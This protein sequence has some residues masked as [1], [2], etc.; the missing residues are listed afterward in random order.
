MFFIIYSISGLENDPSGN[1][2]SSFHTGADIFKS[3]AF[4]RTFYVF[5]CVADSPL[6]N[7]ILLTLRLS[8]NSCRLGVLLFFEITNMVFIL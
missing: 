7:S 3:I 1:S 5:P 4:T 8:N 2:N 6:R